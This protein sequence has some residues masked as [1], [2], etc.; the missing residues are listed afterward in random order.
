MQ[1]PLRFLL[2]LFILLTSYTLSSQKKT[3]QISGKIKS[4]NNDVSNVLI[5][6]L[7][8]KEST[9]TDSLGGFTIEARLR[10]SIRFTA[11][12]YL[13]KE[14]IITETIFQRNSVVV[15]LVE[16]IINLNEVTVTPY[17]L[18]GKLEQDINSLGIEPVV[19]SSTLG[20]P[21]ADV[22]V[23]LQSER[24][25]L[26]AD[27][28]EYARLMTIE[29]ILKLDKTLLGF[30]KI[31]VMV[32]SDKTINRISGK[33]KSLEEIVIR[34]KNIELEEEIIAK[35]SK[36]T[37]SENFDIPEVKIDGFLTYCMSQKDFS[38]IS[39]SGNMLSIWEYLKIKSIEFKEQ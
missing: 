2:L 32:N 18:S 13:T 16:N 26:V 9:I 7:N 4:L 6:N 27:R 15:N 22:K 5:I 21:N 31:S 20:L 12:Q 30:F 33:T 14:I 1:K 34:E 23:M 38:D 24:L 36:K 10:D 11:V 8:S 35:F 29:E 3:K 37:M 17:N 25:L 39:K 19:T 28:G